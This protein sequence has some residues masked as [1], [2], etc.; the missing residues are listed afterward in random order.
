VDGCRLEQNPVIGGSSKQR[1]K[2]PLAKHPEIG[3]NTPNATNAPFSVRLPKELRDAATERA[4]SLE[5]D[6]GQYIRDLIEVDLSRTRPR[7]RRTKYDGIRRSLAEIHA[8][9]IRCSNELELSRARGADAGFHGQMISLLRDAV[10]SML[11]IGRL[12]GPR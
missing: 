10:S 1:R 8:A 9:I 3:C 5:L 6:L 2:A 12:I 4:S 7:R 11:L